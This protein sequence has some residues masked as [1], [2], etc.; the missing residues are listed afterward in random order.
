MNK[1]NAELIIFKLKNK[2]NLINKKEK[3]IRKLSK[4]KN[5]N[6]F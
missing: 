2:N 1:N 3:I 5:K 6:L 4:K